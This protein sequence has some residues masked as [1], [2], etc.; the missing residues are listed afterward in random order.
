MNDDSL[1]HF[2]QALRTEY[3]ATI[4]TLRRAI[5]ACPDSLWNDRKEKEFPFWHIAYHTIF[6]LDL[7]SGDS[8]EMFASFKPQPYHK[9]DNQTLGKTPDAPFTREQVAEYLDATADKALAFID[10]LQAEHLPRRTA[11]SW[12]NL[13]VAEMLLNNLRHVAHHVGQLNATLRR[14]TNRAVG[15]LGS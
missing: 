3:G 13:T 14:E 15:W 11:F 2:K 7:Y 1:S 4:E 10:G 8:E 5:Q 12:Y 6:F 9:K